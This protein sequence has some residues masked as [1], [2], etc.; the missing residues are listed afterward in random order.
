MTRV[1]LDHRGWEA[2]GEATEES[3][4]SYETGWDLVLGAFA[5]RFAPA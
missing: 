2:L 4:A 3:F 5:R 1:E